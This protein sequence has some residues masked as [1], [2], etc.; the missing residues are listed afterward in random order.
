MVSADEKTIT[1]RTGVPSAL[2]EVGPNTGDL[3]GKNE[4]ITSQ[5]LCLL[6]TVHCQIL[7]SPVSPPSCGDRRWQGF[8]QRQE[9]GKHFCIIFMTI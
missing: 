8:H 9:M 7:V 6:F 4:A 3:G 2:P 1:K 5:A